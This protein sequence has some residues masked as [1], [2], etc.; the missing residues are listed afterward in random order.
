M[1][2]LPPKVNLSLGFY[3]LT[4]EGVDGKNDGPHFL[5]ERWGFIPGRTENPKRI[6][7]NNNKLIPTQG[8]H[9]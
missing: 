9:M 6:M 8:F 3:I 1:F 4:A 2:F 7:T 5:K